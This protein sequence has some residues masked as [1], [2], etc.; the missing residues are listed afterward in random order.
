MKRRIDRRAVGAWM[1][2][3][4]ASQPY[5]TLLITFIFAPYFTSAVAA[6]AASGQAVW[7]YTTA[8]AGV[9][10]AVLAPVLGAIADTTGPRKPWLALFSVFYV[11]G[12]ATL[13]LAEPGM[14]DPT[15][16]LGGFALGLIG[17]EFATTFTNAVLP[18]LAP[19]PA[20]GRISGMGWA[21][22]YVG[23]LI[24]LVG[25]MVFLAE[26]E[27]GVTLAGLPPVFALDPELRQGTRAVGPLAALWYA[28]F[29][30]PFFLWVP[31]VP[32]RRRVSGAIRKALGELVDTL[33]A[34]PSRPAFAVY[35]ASTMFYRDA[36]N[37]LYAFG[38]IYAAGVLGWS[39][40][41]VGKF[42]ILAVTAGA[43]GAWMG[44]IA[45]S[46][47]GSKPVIVFWILVLTVTCSGVVMTTR[48]TVLWFSVAP[49]SRLP[50]AAFYLFGAVIGAAGGSLQAASRTLLVHLAA[51]TRMTEAFG[52]YALVGK[53]TSFLA[54][55]SV[56]L[57]T[58]AS[59][60]QRLGVSPVIVL[61]LIGLCL[62]YWVR[63]APEDRGAVT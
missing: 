35:L 19:R 45:D 51:P 54:P 25:T 29:V 23:G 21:A 38:G 28:V 59:G 48:S 47:F 62:L 49:H 43:L 40:I 26:N 6:N 11:T 53:A 1:L 3:D 22:G 61:F 7:G 36:L 14:A 34:L 33:R 17:V 41:D 20:I 10:I 12:A 44:G 2:F 56:A 50:D 9:V 60:S 46:R 27:S 39:V 18:D 37:G 63:I 55:M 8:A 57:V 52:L 4:W 42:G 32:R 5:H 30:I 31:D 15:I 13:W 58:Q 16:V 24:A